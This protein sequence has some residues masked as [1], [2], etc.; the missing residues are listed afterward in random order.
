MRRMRTLQQVQSWRRLRRW[1]L[2]RQPWH[3]QHWWQRQF[4]QQRR[5]RHMITSIG[6]KQ[7][8]GDTAIGG[9]GG[10]GGTRKPSQ[11]G[12]KTKTSST[13]GSRDGWCCQYEKCFRP[14]SQPTGI[15]ALPALAHSCIT[16]QAVSSISCNTRHFPQIHVLGVVYCTRTHTMKIMNVMNVSR[17]D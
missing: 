1:H 4:W 14:V 16:Q 11:Y 5:T 10:T 8:R 3:H 12:G 9:T 2:Q 6:G 7:R 15:S 17:S 13:A